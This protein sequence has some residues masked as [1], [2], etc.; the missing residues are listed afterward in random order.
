M[1]CRTESSWKSTL[2]V[3]KDDREGY[4]VAPN[5]ENE[6]ELRPRSGESKALSCLLTK[7]K[8]FFQLP[9]R[10]PPKREHDPAIRLKEGAEIPHIRPCR[11]P[12]Y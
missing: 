1:L 10:Q 6:P 3:L 12:Y 5:G 9:T 4:F 7:F 8:D 2:K 11:Y